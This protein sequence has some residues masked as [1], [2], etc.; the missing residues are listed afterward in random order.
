MEVVRW[1]RNPWRMGER[2]GRLRGSSGVWLEGDGEKVA[3]L[4][5]DVFGRQGT[6]PEP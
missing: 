3:G 6:D 1:A 5:G 2:M 4:V